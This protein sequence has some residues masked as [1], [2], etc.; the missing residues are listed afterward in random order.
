MAVLRR[1]TAQFPVA[2]ACLNEISDL[3]V[4]VLVRSV[5]QTVLLSE[6]ARRPGQTPPIRSATAPIVWLPPE[7]ADNTC[8][9]GHHATPPG[10]P[11]YSPG[12]AG[13]SRAGRCC[14]HSPDP[15]L[16][17]PVAAP[18]RNHNRAAAQ[19]WRASTYRGC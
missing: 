13:G 5:H 19:S 16:V 9:W 18:S 4:G 17:G 6:C 10:S 11:R 2:H 1:N 14:P 12:V 15:S 8:A 3:L 7:E